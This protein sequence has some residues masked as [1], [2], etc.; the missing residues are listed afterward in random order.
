LSG[1]EKLY[2]YY[3]SRASWE[4][5][6][7][8]YFQR[9]YEA[10]ALLVLLKL[11][12]SS[13]P[14]PDLKEKAMAGGEIDES[15][16][17]QMLAYS[18]SVFQNCGN[19]KSFGDTKFVPELSPE[20]FKAILKSSIAYQNY[21]GVM[22]SIWEKTEKEVY[23][24]VEP[25]Y[26]IA[27]PN[28]NGCSSYYSGDINEDEATRVDEFCQSIKLSPLNTRLFKLKPKE[29]ELKV[30]SWLAD[31]GKTP[32]LKTYEWPVGEEKWTI[33]VTGADFSA[34][35]EKTTKN[36]QHALDY[37]LNENEKRMVADYIEHFTYGDMEIHK[38]SQRHWIK[39]VGPTVE[40][41][42]G[43]I[44]TYLDPLG[45]RAEFE[46]FVAIVDKKVS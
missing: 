37:A 27:F 39:D 7:I 33:H 16:W 32:Y 46:G 13:Q 24:E 14:L 35:M 38:N 40:C 30:A 17:R 1:N 4:G 19:Y 20:K 34:F 36:M 22:E 8:C 25:Y 31:A 18:A 15:N 43:F 41:N 23:T 2:A 42:I 10:P 12:Y 9:S 6:K 45:A 44:E 26:Q 29:Y 5:S 3:L 11:L 21:Q 28:K